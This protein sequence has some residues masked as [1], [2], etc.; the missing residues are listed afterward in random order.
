MNVLPWPRWLHH[1]L[2]LPRRLPRYPLV[3]QRNRRNRADRSRRLFPVQV[4][5][6]PRW[7]TIS[8]NCRPTLGP[9]LVKR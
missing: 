8:L 4:E 7:V 2:L 6:L 9:P 3:D 1:W 5:A